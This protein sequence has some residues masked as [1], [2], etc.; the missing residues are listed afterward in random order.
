MNQKIQKLLCAA[1][2]A[3]CVGAAGFGFSAIKDT[4]IT[5]KAEPVADIA[6]TK[7]YI[8]SNPYKDVDWDTWGHYKAATHVHTDIS[9]GNIKFAQQIENYY[10]LGYDCLGITDH[11]TVNYGWAESKSRHTIFSYQALSYGS[12]KGLSA[13]RNT[14]ITTGVGRNG[15]GM[16]DIPMG[17]ELN[18]SSTAKC[19]INGFFADAG[20][21]DMELSSSGVSGCVTAV[22]KN[23]KAGGLTHINH[24]GEF[25]SANDQ[26]TLAD[27]KANVYTTSFIDDFAQKVFRTYSSCVGMELV[28]KGDSRT[29]YDRYLYDELLMRLAPEGR[30]LWGFCEDDA[31]KN[32]E[33]AKNVQTFMMPSNTAANVRTAMETGAFFASTI[34]AN[35]DLP[36]SI[37]HTDFQVH[38]YPMVN[39]ITIDDLHSQITFEIVNAD[40]AVLITGD[41]LGNGGKII[42][43]VACNTAGSVVTFDLNKYE[44]D[45]TKGY[46]RIYF[47]GPDGITYVQPFYLTEESYATHVPVTFNVTMNG[48]PTSAF[49]ISIKNSKGVLMPMENTNLVNISA[50]ETYTYSVSSDGYATVTG[51]FVISDTDFVD[52]KSYSLDI[53]L[54]SIP[55]LVFNTEDGIEADSD[56]KFITG[57]SLGEQSCEIAVSS[58]SYGTVDV[59]PTEN[60]YGTGTKVNLIF[61]GEVIDSYTYVIYGDTDGDA[62]ADATDS[63]LLEA[64]LNPNVQCSIS[65]EALRASDVN[66][67]GYY[68]MEDVKVLRQIGMLKEYTIEQNR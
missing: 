12:A 37:S 11:G 48:Q 31:H 46:V 57:L 45:I 21:G 50:P 1:A 61:N 59:V 18:G 5:A 56:T 16:I 53:A 39:R 64:F 62:K 41:S 32:G 6:G 35:G 13:S 40:N 23:H 54:Q 26:A 29:R 38:N 33:I 43:T 10:G 28:N 67:D 63:I 24:V 15:R 17:I 20:D 44:K 4:Q 60:G 2:A 34:N 65:P 51:S 30:F 42:D 25:M 8:I 58:N 68:D 36:T 49:S 19:H 47:T 66:N 52:S 22:S 27:C 3:L 55:Q 9:D 7:R 14:E